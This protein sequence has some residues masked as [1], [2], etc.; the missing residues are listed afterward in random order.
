MP[1]PKKNRW[2]QLANYLIAVCLSLL[3]AFSLISILLLAQGY[4]PLPAFQA[5]LEGAFQGYPNLGT[6]FLYATP[7]IF[8]GLGI[9]LSFKSGIFN[10]GA[11]GQLY[12]GA[13]AATAVGAYVK[14]PGLL[15]ILLAMAA[16]MAAGALWA[17]IPGFLKISR[18]FNEV[19]T[20]VLLNYVAVNFV[21]FMLAGP[22]KDR[23]V[24]NNQSMPVAPG[25]RLATLAK[26][27]ELNAG[28]LLAL[29]A[30]VVFFVI[31]YRTDWG[32]RLRAVG[33]NPNCSRAVGINTKKT[34][35]TAIVTSG[36]LSG[37]AG[38]VQ[39]LGYQYI[40]LQNFSPNTGFDCIAVAL[41]GNLHPFGVLAAAV[42]YG[43]LRNGVSV[44]QIFT[45]IPVTIVFIMQGIIVLS[46]LAF[47]QSKIDFI[48]WMR[49]CFSPR[50]AEKG[51]A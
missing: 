46:V 37:L 31:F 13:L 12:L 19:I 33:F 15:H 47:S 9:A 24:H 6:S 20:S 17:F 51:G 5:L 40:M 10:I 48:A 45:G 49:K 22:M 16:G 21:N 30:V 8:G 32:F 26:G 11:E 7:L 34:L 43:S 2:M 23:G 35:L 29:C 50:T 38:T 18:G 1:V 44:M 41:L 36:A 14:A 28:F 39:I 3:L 42:F 27:S 25:A 4:R